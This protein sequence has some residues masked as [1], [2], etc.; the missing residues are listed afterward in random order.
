MKMKYNEWKWIPKKIFYH[1]SKPCLQNMCAL[2][3]APTSF[4]K[5]NELQ[6]NF[7]QIFLQHF[8]T[9]SSKS[10][11]LPGV[12]HLLCY[13][14]TDKCILAIFIWDMRYM[15]KPH[16]HHGEQL[17]CHR[18]HYSSLEAEGVVGA[19]ELGIKWLRDECALGV[20]I[21]LTVWHSGDDR[22]TWD[23]GENSALQWPC[24]NR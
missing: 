15:K 2:S 3:I 12:Q 1:N 17:I 10:P 9:K 4:W 24:F 16:Y 19:A 20:F 22:Q 14:S 7:F 8:V 23:S 13:L 5:F 18:A 6:Y 21:A 11:S